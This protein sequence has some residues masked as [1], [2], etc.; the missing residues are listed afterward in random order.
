MKKITQ[1]FLMLYSFLFL[2]G[3]QKNDNPVATETRTPYTG[4]QVTFTFIRNSNGINAYIL[5]NEATLPINNVTL[6]YCYNI[7]PWEY[8]NLGTMQSNAYIFINAYDTI[9]ISLQYDTLKYY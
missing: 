2:F 8:M 9:K 1:I 3:C 4:T 6:I 5:K 7:R